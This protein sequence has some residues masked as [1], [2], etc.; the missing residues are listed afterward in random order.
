[1][2]E[3]VFAI[4]PS[5]HLG[6]GRSPSRRF[7]RI[8][9]LVGRAGANRQICLSSGP[10]APHQ[11]R[12]LTLGKA[13]SA[14]SPSPISALFAWIPAEAMKG[15]KEKI[16]TPDCGVCALSLGL[17]REGLTLWSWP[18]PGSWGSGGAEQGAAWV[19][20]PGRVVGDTVSVRATGGDLASAAALWPPAAAGFRGA[21][22]AASLRASAE[23][24]APGPGL[25]KRRPRPG[26][27]R[28]APRSPRPHRHHDL[29][30]ADYLRQP[31][32][33]R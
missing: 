28:P 3:T 11:L 21:S 20:P 19:E 16:S 31:L 4:H 32:P 2:K 5:L 30:G 17:G 27:H 1:M 26:R 25:F 6:A 33:R 24:A 9:I 12:R 22:E 13:G 29:P 15:N 23:A 7:L 18:W 8:C 10:A 14:S